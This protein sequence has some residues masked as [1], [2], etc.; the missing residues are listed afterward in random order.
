MPAE[1]CPAAGGVIPSTST[2]DGA[3]TDLVERDSELAAIATFVRRG[4]VMLIEAGAGVGKT[5][6][7][8]ATC[9]IAQRKKRTVLRARGSELER[10]FA[11]GVVR[12]LFEHRF[13]DA[14]AN[15]REALLAGPARPVATL[16]QRDDSSGAAH[17][18]GFAVLHGLYWLTVNLSDHAPLVLAVDDVHWADEASARWL[19]YLAPRLDGPNVSLVAALRPEEPASRSQP[20]VAVR[21][22]AATTIRPSLLSPLA[23]AAVVRKTLGSGA[24]DDVCALAHRATGGNPFY[25]RELLRALE[26]AGDPS[27]LRALDDAVGLGGVDAVALQLRA[28]LQ[29]INPAALR[30]AQTLAILG[31]GCDLRHAAAIAHLAMDQATYLATELVRL[32]VLGEDR[33][34]RF[35]HPIVRHAVA[36]TMSGAEQD[37][38]HRAAARVLHAER[39]QPGRVAAHLRPLRGAGDGWVVERLRDAARAAIDSGAPAAAADLLDRALAEPPASGI[40]VDVLRETARAQQLAGREGACRLLQEAIAITTDTARRAHLAS[41]L[42]QAH[43]ALFRWTDAVEVLESALADSH[44]AATVQLE[45]QLVAVG[46]QDARTASRALRVMKRLERRTLSG[47]PATALAVAQG[48]VA[49]LTGRPADETAR[50]LQAALRSATANAEAWD[51]RAA[52]LWSLLTAER[53]DAVA[54]ALVP[55]REQA[56]RSGSSR[57]LVAVYSTAALLKLK[58]GDL[59]H[60]DAAA[61]TALHV[62]QHGDFAGGLAFTAT[63]LAEIAVAGGQLDEAQ[64]LLDLLPREDLP[65]GVGTV[66]IPAA[67]GRLR[68]AQGRA[69]E[70][71]AEFE[72]CMTLWQPRRWGMRMT[73]TGYLHARA[74]AAQALLALGDLRRAR[75][76]ADAEVADTRRFGGRRALGI[77]LRTAGLA[78]GGAK[79]LVM[80]EESAAV[81]G[82]SPALLERSASLIEW[83]AALRRAG[84][85]SQ[86]RRMLARGRDGAARC[87]A[88]PLVARAREELRVA[89]A[90]PRRDWSVGVE[91]LTPS[92]LR[93]VRLAHDGRTNRQIA[94]ELY[95]SI[96][97]VEG[98]LARTYG[99]LGIASRQELDRALQPEKTRVP[100]L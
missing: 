14:I 7:L 61:R 31:D 78:R 11:F 60:A 46:L 65:A 32:E 87:G 44:A 16:F 8:E 94:Q 74:G 77:S 91:A 85:R 35:L 68:L 9:A 17:D 80:L 76:L 6:L 47:A 90:R 20:L 58:L 73:D 21:A 18:T 3:M 36:H 59:A 55:L 42:A 45:S 43:A 22:A 75:E 99:K 81:L 93:I 64:A 26:R 100:A 69:R 27:E 48:M 40:R 53:F 23:V 13:T 33:P 67:R 10:D 39:A 71:L 63:L 49:L 41:D 92:E 4:G 62:A 98:H 19:A 82:E 57:G 66:L 54:A 34:P 83:G 24:A 5:S 1:R 37:A 84:Q 89:G 70:A 29:T 56:D 2:S 52:L 95:L 88:R 12:Q 30:L 51:M 86:A 79:G 97:T 96:K 28:R 25:L 50:P 38:A 72:A 15:D